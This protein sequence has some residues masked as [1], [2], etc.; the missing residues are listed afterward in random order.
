MNKA[1]RALQRWCN[2]DAY[3]PA[4]V[5]GGFLFAAFLG[6]GI[7]YWDSDFSLFFKAVWDRSLLGLLW[8]WISPIYKGPGN[9]GFQDRP[10]QFIVYKV[11][12][13]IAGYNT[14]PHWLFKDLS[15]AGLGLMMYMWI[16]RLAPGARKAA[17][18]AVIF[19]LAAPGPTAAHIWLADF[20]PTAEL[21]FLTLTFVL[22]RLIED[23]PPEYR[24]IS[25]MGREER[26]QW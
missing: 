7:P 18:A 12:Y 2:A 3:R 22:W 9:W 14:W 21:T 24:W 15:Y 26:H 1:F 25:E 11:C 5:I 16:L 8:D 6:Q 10:A 4:L 20:A 17:L 19:F 13:L 23:T